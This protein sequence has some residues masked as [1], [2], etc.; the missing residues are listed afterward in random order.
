[1]NINQRTP[2]RSTD[3]FTARAGASILFILACGSLLVALDALISSCIKLGV[4]NSLG[5]GVL[6]CMPDSTFWTATIAILAISFALFVASWMLLR[7]GN[8][9]VHD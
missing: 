8:D 2:K 7:T 9:N 4:K 5:S 6:H 1:M 3:K